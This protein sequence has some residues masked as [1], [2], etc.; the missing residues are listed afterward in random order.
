MPHSGQGGAS[1]Q[2]PNSH[3]A[4]AEGFPQVPP[5]FQSHFCYWNK[6]Q[7]PGWGQV[8]S[9]ARSGP[10]NSPNT[11][12]GLALS[13]A[14]CKGCKGRTGPIKHVPDPAGPMPRAGGGKSLPKLCKAL[15]VPGAILAHRKPLVSKGPRTV[16]SRTALVD[17]RQRWDILWRSV[18][19]GTSCKAVT[20]RA[21][22]A[23]GRCSAG[24]TGDVPRS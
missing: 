21:S 8:R 15:G 14:S 6:W 10:K 24:R 11:G 2:P 18:I 1:L 13:P 23:C 16:R 3:S 19:K 7:V 9:Q 5:H 4:S 17:P 20:G 22:S 12:T